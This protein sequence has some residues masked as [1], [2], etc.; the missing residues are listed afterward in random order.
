MTRKNIV[1]VVVKTFGC[2]LLGLLVC[3]SARAQAPTTAP[4]A[5]VTQ[6]LESGGQI[7]MLVNKSR[8]LN[9]NR[10]YKRLSVAQPEVADVNALS[11]T[12]FMVTAKK[13]GNTQLVVWDMQDQPQVLEVVVDID[14][15]GVRDR[16]RAV[17]PNSNI[18][19]ILADGNVVLR[20]RLANLAAV[21]QAVQLAGASGKVVNL[22]EIAGEQQVMLQV[23]FAEVSRTA[24]SALGINGAVVAGQGFGGSN[25]GGVN[26]T[27]L[28]PG[29]GSILGRTP[30]PSGLTL[31]GD[32]A[33]NPSVTLYGGG[34]IGSVFVEA[35]ISA[36]RENNLLRV[37]AEPN[38]V[39]TSGQEASFLAG[40]EFPIPV[41]QG[42]T[43]QS[44]SISIEFREFGVRLKFVPVVLG[45]GRIRLKVAPEVSD[46]D[47]STAVRFS[48]FVVP[49]LSQRKVTTT[50]ELGDGQTFAV[51]GL[52]SNSVAANKSVTPVLG[53]LPILGPL[54]RS[55]RYQRKETELV[56]LVTPR[57]VSGLRPSEIPPLP[58]ESWRHPSESE[59][60]YGQ[61]LGG[62]AKP[63]DKI[64][65]RRAPV[66]YGPHGFAPAT[67]PARSSR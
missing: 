17:F 14:I 18:E 66:F 52:L 26:P 67:Q 22:L 8:V 20:G 24:V 16:F 30:P 61:D 33:I 46:L 60:F 28:I 51:A 1:A 34:Q 27:S 4:D 48:G 35:F 21:E 41:V 32:Q 55:V 19:V 11:S 38:L 37:L 13:A 56:V 31:T 62:P 42:G 47:F 12:S 44:T 45:D 5:L 39:A 59:L 3:G 49:G 43:A 29:E 2:A 7:R 25:I 58:G 50:V 36:L 23:R 40:G 10:T 15:Q 54:F 65:P 6:G 63:G 64:Q 53:D 57:L 9:T